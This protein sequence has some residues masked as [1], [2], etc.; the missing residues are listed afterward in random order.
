MSTLWKRTP[1]ERR[2]PKVWK[3][4]TTEDAI[5]VREKAKNTIKPKTINTCWRKRSPDVVHD[6]TGFVTESLKE[7]MK[8]IVDM[9]IIKKNRKGF[10]IWVLEKFTS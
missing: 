8:E 5:I 7:I 2:T 9:I 3:D 6:F 1:R 4:Y 10:K